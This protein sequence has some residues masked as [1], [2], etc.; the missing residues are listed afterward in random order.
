MSD[1]LKVER[2]GD[3]L[4]VTIDRQE[5][6]NAL[7]QAVHDGLHETWTSLHADPSVRSIVI[8]K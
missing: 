7:S 8:T 1:E 2:R 4:V 6:M 5:R 3:V